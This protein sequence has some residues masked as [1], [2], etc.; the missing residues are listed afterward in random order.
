MYSTA[1]PIAD[2]LV[3]AYRV[4][5]PRTAAEARA[6]IEAVKRGG[7]LRAAGPRTRRISFPRHVMRPRLGVRWT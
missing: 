6:I 4:V 2:E 1:S 5:D 3:R 7:A